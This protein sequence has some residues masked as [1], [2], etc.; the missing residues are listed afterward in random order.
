[1]PSSS[2]KP[3]PTADLF[4]QLPKGITYY[5]PSFSYPKLTPKTRPV[6][7]G[8]T[9]FPDFNPKKSPSH[10]ACH[11]DE[12]VGG[13]FAAAH[14]MTPNPISTAVQGQSREK[15]ALQTTPTTRWYWMGLSSQILAEETAATGES[16]CF[17]SAAQREIWVVYI[18]F[19]TFLRSTVSLCDDR[20]NELFLWTRVNY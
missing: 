5:V 18:P 1:M 7:Q 10:L 20:T 16:V 9:F 4:L 2:T 6:P 8:C 17:D 12:M 19:W 11:R 13:N 15:E 3:E 14:L